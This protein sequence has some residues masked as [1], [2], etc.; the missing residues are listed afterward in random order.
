MLSM[1]L[2]NRKFDGDESISKSNTRERKSLF[3]SKRKKS[4]KSLK[5][6]QTIKKETF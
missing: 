5:S 3:N 1:S 4:L 2:K 6:L